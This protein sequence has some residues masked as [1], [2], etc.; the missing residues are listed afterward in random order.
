M[1]MRIIDEA[2]GKMMVHALCKECHNAI[3][4]HVIVKEKGVA[5]I[6]IRTDLSYE[7]FVLV[8]EEKITSDDVLEVHDRCISNSLLKDFAQKAVKKQR[9]APVKKTCP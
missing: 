8:S 1:Q 5:I 2:D 4:A 7:D 3:M 6:G 9:K